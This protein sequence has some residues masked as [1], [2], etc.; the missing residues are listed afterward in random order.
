MNRRPAR[1]VS[2]LCAS[3]DSDVGGGVPSMYDVRKWASTSGSFQLSTTSPGTK[4]SRG[5]G[6]S[7]VFILSLPSRQICQA[8]ISS[9]GL[10]GEQ[11]IRGDGCFQGHS[12]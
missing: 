8:K 3:S 9:E 11:G 5:L 10:L 12:K 4:L 2:R 7:T 6:M 1:W